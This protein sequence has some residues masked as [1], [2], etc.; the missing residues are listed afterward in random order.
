MPT[1]TFGIATD[2]DDGGGQRTA[3]VWA[4]IATGTFAPDDGT[5]GSISKALFGG[6]FFVFNSYFRFNTSTLPDD[7]TVTAAVL[8]I[9][10]PAGEL[11]DPDNIDYAGDF[12]DFGGE[13]STSADWEQ[14][15]SGDA[16]A[17]IDASSLTSGAVN[18]LSLTGLSGVSLTG[19]TGLRLAPKTTAQPTGDNFVHIAKQEDTTPSRRPT[20]EVTYTEAGA[21][22]TT[23]R[24]YQIRRS[25]ATSW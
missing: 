22:D 13:P 8:K 12:F 17:T 7:A 2:A 18:N 11:A 5:P 16:I 23:T 1:D 21:G 24:R 14:S 25:R 19:I 3:N 20:L 4:D 9:F 10:I 15:S 6:D